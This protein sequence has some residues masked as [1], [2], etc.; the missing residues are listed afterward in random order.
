VFIG[1]TLALSVDNYKINPAIA[2]TNAQITIE[3]MV[4]VVLAILFIT[5]NWHLPSFSDTSPALSYE[6]V[7]QTNKI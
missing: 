1:Y 4:G 3:D 5:L 2:F 7:V 6:L